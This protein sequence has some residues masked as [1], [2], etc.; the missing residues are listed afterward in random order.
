MTNANVNPFPNPDEFTEGALVI[1][2]VSTYDK[3]VFQISPLI[4]D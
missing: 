4:T 3:I 2:I 1:L